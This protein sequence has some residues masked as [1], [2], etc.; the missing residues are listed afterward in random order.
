MM[1]KALRSTLAPEWERI[2]LLGACL[3][4]S[5]Q[6][7]EVSSEIKSRLEYV[8]NVVLDLRSR[9]PWDS[10]ITNQGL[11]PLDQDIL[12]C[13]VAPDAEPR[14]GWMFQ[15]LQSGLGS[16]YPTPA[17]MRELF[18][19]NDFDAPIF[20][21]RLLQHSPLVSS[22]L[23][24]RNNEDLFSPL[25]PT[26]TA[27]AALLGWPETRISH[28]PPGSIEIEAG[29]TW[30]D[31]VLPADAI[32]SLRE[33]LLWITHRE[34]VVDNWG[35]KILGGPVALFSGPSGTGKTF[36]A[37]VLAN[38]LGWPL[39][40]VD[41]GLLVSKYVGETEKNLNALFDA[42]DGQRTI[43][44]FDE[45]DSLFGK[46][47]EVKEARD[48]YANMEVSHLLSRME[49]HNGPCILTTNLR[50]Y[51]DSAFARRFQMTI[52]FPRPDAAARA[53]LWR[54]LLPPHANY[55]AQVDPMFLGESLNFT[56]GQIRN[57]ALH[58]AFLAAGASES[59]NLHHIA[60]AAWTELAKDGKERLRSS[61]GALAPYVDRR[62]PH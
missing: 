61:L 35:A 23:I 32:A 53:N 55:D 18:F 8:Q 2:G 26:S 51:L 5:R 48:R 17:L 25:K 29:G 49:R 52:E 28:S 56:G 7:V 15:D 58:A 59:I 24:V 60:C 6:G 16:S 21:E 27:R 45:A 13:V 62:N 42:A 1:A 31:L 47:G 57:V 46:R 43:L 36:A 38:E 41:L 30:K 50:R 33:I 12:S 10:L 9:M 3:S 54:K 14:I 39:Y 22:G 40:R 20:N 37:S 34:Q 19:M 11:S 4:S 44:L